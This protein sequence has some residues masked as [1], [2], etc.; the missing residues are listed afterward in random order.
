M[1]P[2]LDPVKSGRKAHCSRQGTAL[3]RSVSTWCLPP[4]RYRSPWNRMTV[5]DGFLY[6]ATWE[7]DFRLRSPAAHSSYP[8]FRGADS[9]RAW[10]FWSY[11]TRMLRISASEV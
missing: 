3:S 11:L 9:A 4:H 7:E 8:K 5:R 10:I 2:R 1:T 6:T